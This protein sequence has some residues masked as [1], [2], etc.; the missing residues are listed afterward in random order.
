MTTKLQNE[1][2]I[3]QGQQGGPKQ[4]NQNA[5]GG[6]GA[7]QERTSKSGVMQQGADVLPPQQNQGDRR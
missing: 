6:L 2:A 5:Q 3:E 1:R 7:E 4:K